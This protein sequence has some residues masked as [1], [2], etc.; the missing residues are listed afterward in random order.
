MRHQEDHIAHNERREP[1]DPKFRH[2]AEGVA[3]K[4]VVK[5][6]EI[7]DIRARDRN[8]GGPREVTAFERMNPV[9]PCRHARQ[10]GI[11][12]LEGRHRKRLR[13][14][15]RRRERGRWATEVERTVAGQGNR[16]RNK[17]TGGRVEARGRN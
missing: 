1:I 7:A 13:E 12:F 6:A 17:K 5:S 11:P 16:N 3:Y 8:H 14:W 4:R 15:D 9:V 2:E 10:E